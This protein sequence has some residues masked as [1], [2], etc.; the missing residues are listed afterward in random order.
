M[1]GYS[2]GPVSLLFTASRVDGAAGS[3]T[4]ADIDQFGL[5]LNTRF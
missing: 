2:L 1:L 5:S 4:A 3:A